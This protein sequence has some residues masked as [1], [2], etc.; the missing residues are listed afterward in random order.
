MIITGLLSFE[1]P[2]YVA[3]L[4]NQNDIV[5]T[6]I[7]ILENLR[8]GFFRVEVPTGKNDLV[9][10]VGCILMDESVLLVVVGVQK[11]LDL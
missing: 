3:G 2:S 7:L 10:A 9:F 1:I 4:G 11:F 8:G 5:L 6:Q